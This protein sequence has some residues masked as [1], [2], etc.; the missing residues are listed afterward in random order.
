[1]MD[2]TFA[3]TVWGDYGKYLPEWGESIAAQT[4]LPRS[5]VIADAGVDD[6]SSVQSTLKALREVGIK[7]RRIRIERASIG[8]MRN[9]AM[10]AVKTEW[11]M[12]LDAD[13]VLLPHAIEDALELGSDA[14]VVALGAERD[15]R[16]VLFTDTSADKI[17]RGR[18]GSMSPSPFRT[19]MWKRRP[20]LTQNDWIE[21]AFWVGLAHL[22][23]RFVGTR[24]PGFVY[25][26][27]DD[28]HSRQLSREDKRHA[29]LQQL[30]LCQRWEP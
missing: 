23:A 8:D 3:T 27:H 10:S 16:T 5:V 7:C 28:S 15:G 22:G 11:A 13:D 25:R 18:Q 24:R 20:Y 30:R 19:E 12:H 9:S 1:M 14:D 2:I 21:S 26:Q 29:R 17:L 4:V 6:P